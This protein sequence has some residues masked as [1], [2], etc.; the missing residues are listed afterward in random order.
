MHASQGRAAAQLP[1]P[2]RP[3]S[4]LQEGRLDIV[5][6]AWRRMHNQQG[7]SWELSGVPEPPLDL[8]V[9]D[10]AAR[11]VLI[12]CAVPGLLNGGRERARM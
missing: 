8:R 11:Q 3:A 5:A 9:T 6:S 1:E 4:C 2:L 10:G 12:R 7:A